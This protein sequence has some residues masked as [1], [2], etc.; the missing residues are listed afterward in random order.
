MATA[1]QIREVVREYAEDFVALEKL[2]QRINQKRDAIWESFPYPKVHGSGLQSRLE[3]A[4]AVNDRNKALREVEEI[5]LSEMQ[6]KVSL[7]EWSLEEFN[8][9]LVTLLEGVSSSNFVVVFRD[10]PADVLIGFHRPL[11]APNYVSIEYD[12]P[13]EEWQKEKEKIQRR[14]SMRIRMKT[15]VEKMSW[16]E[17]FKLK[18]RLFGKHM[19][20]GYF[21]VEF[22]EVFDQEKYP[23]HGRVLARYYRSLLGYEVSWDSLDKYLLNAKATPS[24]SES[25]WYEKIFATDS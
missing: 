13:K 11:R 9:Y 16:W 17:R 10:R 15:Y 8:K 21:P 1:D 19:P 24:P 25:P 23:E 6:A 3:F 7:L 2:Q 5:E 4:Q 20:S 14:D 12:R 18:F 22:Q